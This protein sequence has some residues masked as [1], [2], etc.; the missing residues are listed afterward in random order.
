[1]SGMAN[2]D[3]RAPL[4]GETDR[5]QVDL[6]DKRARGVDGLQAAITGLRRTCGPDAVRA[7]DQAAP[8]RNFIDGV[9]EVHSP[10]AKAFD[11]MIV[12]DNLVVDVERRSKSST[13]PI[14]GADR[15]HDAG[16]KAVG[17]GQDDSHGC[18]LPE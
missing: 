3:H 7:I 13:A 9:N 4:C 6:R 5:L 18:S 16:T 10:P 17:I 15:H 1:M 8:L 14:Q 12:M 2:Q 11:D